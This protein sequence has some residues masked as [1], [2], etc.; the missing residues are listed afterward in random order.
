MWQKNE[1]KDSV[2]AETFCGALLINPNGNF[3]KE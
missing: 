1:F 2:R 3:L